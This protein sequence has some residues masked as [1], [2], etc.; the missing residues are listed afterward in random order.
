MSLRARLALLFGVLG[1]VVSALVGVLAYRV[2]RV[3]LAD[4]TDDFLR[5]RAGEIS[6]GIRP[7][8]DRRGP[9]GPPPNVVLPFDPDAISRIIGRNGEVVN[10]SGGTLPAT[11]ALADLVD[12]RSG[13]NRD[14]KQV[15]EDIEIDGEPYRM[16]TQSLPEGGVVQVAR[17]TAETEAVETNLVTRFALIAAGGGLLAALAGWFIARRTTAPLRR[18][19]DVAGEVAETRD[20]ST[21]ITISRTDEIGQLAGSFQEMLDALE[22]SR[23][24]QHRLVHDAGHELRTPLTSLRANVALLERAKNLPEA[25][26]AEILAA[27]N[28]ELGELTGLFTELID[29][30]TDQG[31]LDEP[32]EVLDMNDVVRTTVQRWQR[33]VDRPIRVESTSAYVQGHEAMLER[34]LT[35]LL[36][37]ANKFSDPGEPVEVVAR[38]GSVCV[39]DSGPGIPEADRAHVFE[40]FYRADVTRSMPGSGLGLAIVG[41]IVERHG[42]TTW[43]AESPSGGAEVGFRLP[44][45]D[46]PEVTDGDEPTLDEQPM[47][48]PV[49]HAAVHDGR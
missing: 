49:D 40:R 29:L 38:A 19:A 24:Q 9:P 31:E 32:A 6:A 34:A 39:R 13:R 14:P 5:Q 42:G 48:Q 12:E 18:L 3:E 28:A 1:L 16:I 11:A 25:E 43:V 2:T 36:G 41:Q 37:N 22:T 23:E 26:R 20:F 33:R 30:A 45:V 4:T 8:P 47:E 15:F 46:P 44:L 10:E 17:S 7:A 35:N 27:V 21:E